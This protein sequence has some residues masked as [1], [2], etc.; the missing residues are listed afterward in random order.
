MNIAILG[1]ILA[2][3][4]S[5]LGAGFAI[6]ELMRKL[7]YRIL[8]KPEPPK[9]YAARLSELT[10]S[11]T[12]ASA[13]VDS[14]LSE[15]S[16]VAREKETYV[17]KLEEGL[18]SLAQQ[19]KELKEKIEALE[20]VPIPAAK[21][22]AKLMEPGERRSAMRDYALFGT[23]VLVTTLITIVIQIFTG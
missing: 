3:L 8:G 14:L 2:A 6:T 7:L 23:G 11:L 18:A 19:E 1:A 20:N 4:T 17:K 10:R 15:L 21:H 22:F 13:E 12:N 16:N 5:L 9:T